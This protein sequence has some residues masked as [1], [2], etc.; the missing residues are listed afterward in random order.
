MKDVLVFFFFSLCIILHFNINSCITT[1]TK[2]S[3][4]PKILHENAILE[5]LQKS[6][7]V[8]DGFLFF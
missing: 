6:K 7:S 1:C 4:L 2:E 5:N 3:M 8:R